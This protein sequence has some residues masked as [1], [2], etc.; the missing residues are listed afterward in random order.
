MNQPADL[1]LVTWQGNKRPPVILPVGFPADTKLPKYALGDRC[2]WIPNPNTDWGVVIGQ[3]YAPAATE[4]P[5]DSQWLWLYLL[6]LDA[7]SPSRQWLMADWVEEQ[8][9]ERLPDSASSQLEQA[10]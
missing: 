6:L 10:R 8:E 1:N 2:R 5:C 3:I 4:P 9:L 7:D